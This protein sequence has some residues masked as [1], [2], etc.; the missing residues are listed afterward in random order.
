VLDLDPLAPRTPRLPNRRLGALTQLTTSTALHLTLVV[1]AALIE[2][3]LARVVDPRRAEPMIDQQRPDV[4]HLVFLAPELPRTGRGGGGGGNERHD[5]ISR[6]QG[7]GTDTITL[8]VRKRP[9]P[10]APISAPAVE[11]VPSLPSVVLDAKPLASGL[12]DQ[13]GL[14]T[15]AVMSSTSTGP[16]SGGGVGTGSG[17]GMGSGRGPGLGP[18]S[19]GGTG[20][21]VYRAGGTVSAPRLIKEVR[22][23][24]TN[25][26]LAN[27]IQGQ[28]VLEAVVTED[29]CASQ[30]RVVR[31]LDG[32]G[33]DEEA[34]AAVAQWRFEPGRL[35]G[36]PVDVLVTIVL[37]FSVR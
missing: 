33:L 8:R 22:P 11:D 29:G 30:I 17:T 3:T 7:V 20:G 21:G 5:P 9:P 35:G 10:T 14:P 1:I 24:Y 4:Q 12:F 18:G 36:A 15:G 13:I 31:S 25:E 27:K 28:V 16:G 23:K 32:G 37:S 34:V 2:T 6:A 19:G 26:A